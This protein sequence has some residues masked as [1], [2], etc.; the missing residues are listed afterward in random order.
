MPERNS[1][2]S[3]ASGRIQ[4]R[5]TGAFIVRRPA[6]IQPAVPLNGIKGGGDGPSVRHGNH[7]QMTQNVKMVVV[8]REKVHRTHVIVVVF[9]AEAV[10]FRDPEGLVQSGGRSLPVGLARKR[11]PFV[12]SDSYQRLDI[13]DQFPAVGLHP[14]L[15]LFLIHISPHLHTRKRFPAA[16]SA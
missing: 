4:G 8:L 11:V 15:N 6:P 14:L 1:K 5:H 2:L 12:T 9:H 10:G 7:V 13:L 16:P 3:D